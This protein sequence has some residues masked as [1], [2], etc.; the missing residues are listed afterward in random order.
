MKR[1]I[2]KGLVVLIFTILL[3][4][5]ISAEII[6]TQPLKSSYNLGDTVFVPITIKTLTGVSG[7]INMNLVCNGTEIGFY[8]NGINLV[9]GAEKSLDS[10]LVLIRSIIG[11]NQ[12]TCK[13][14]VILGS[15]YTLSNEFKISNLLTIGGVMQKSIFNSGENVQITGKVTRETGEN[16]NGFIDA[17]I[18]TNDINQNITQS[19][20]ITNGVFG[21]NISLPSNLKAGDYFVNLNAYEE[22][23]DGLQT[24]TGNAQYNISVR[25]VPTNLELIINS[26]EINPG[27]Q[28]QASA[29]LHDQ[30]GDAIN[31]TVFLTLKDSSDKIIDQKELNTGESFT[32]TT[33]FNEPPANW[34]IFAASSQLTAEGSFLIKTKESVDIQIVNKTISVTNNGNVP[35][36]KTLLVKIGDTP[37][38]IQVSLNLGESKKYALTAPD[39]QYQVK[40]VGNQDNEV[41]GTM[42]L[43][44]NAVGIKES[45]SWSSLGVIVGWTVLIS[46]LAAGAFF[47]VKKVRKKSFFGRMNFGKSKS[48]EVPVLKNNSL[49]TLGKK[50][51]M[52]LS[53]NGDK[54]DA[55][56]VCLKIKNL[57]EITSGRGSASDIIGKITDLAEEKSAAV[58]ENQDYLFFIFAPLKTRTFKNEESA[59]ELAE[60][61]QKMLIEQNRMFNQKINFG[62]SLDFGSIVAKMENGVFRFMSL[63]S[64]MTSA[65]K[66][67]SLSNEEV[68]L[69][70]KINDLVRVHIRAEKDIREGTTVFVLGT[71]KKEDEATK[72]FINKFMDRQK[73]G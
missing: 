33:A 36:N 42:S 4:S 19:A 30:T 39:G 11:G 26:K 52:S 43:T 73:R 29:I 44:G 37:L 56:I 72:N 7:V 1:G 54:Q 66:I 16:A 10:S 8:K 70:D 46:I 53:V 18:I 51:E 21:M 38:N 3:T 28:I 6:F 40:I 59:L 24:N 61:I 49:T 5:F 57:S 65:K 32:Y 69:S 55:S 35:Y 60:N 50:A 62:I 63:G 13:V 12:G 71:I 48:K 31:S 68:L 41:T 2:E 22:D 45:S 20:T 47:G 9:A 58:Y 15:D 27:E 14:K 34:K 17:N 64:L 25:Q 23:S 67:A